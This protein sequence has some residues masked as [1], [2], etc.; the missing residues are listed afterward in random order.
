MCTVLLLHFY[1]RECS[2]SF[3]KS[4]VMPL[5]RLM[6]GCRKFVGKIVLSGQEFMI[7]PNMDMK[8]SQVMTSKTLANVKASNMCEKIIELLFMTYLKNVELAMIHSV[9]SD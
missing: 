1:S 4:L 8:M 9:P 5:L 2:S 7:C 6:Q 3:A